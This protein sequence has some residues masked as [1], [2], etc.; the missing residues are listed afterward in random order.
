MRGEVDLTSAAMRL[1]SRVIAGYTMK[2]RNG[3]I[4]AM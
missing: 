1:S 4:A 2:C 3:L